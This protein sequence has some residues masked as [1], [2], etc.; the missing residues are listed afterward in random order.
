MLPGPRAMPCFVCWLDR[1][2]GNVLFV[3]QWALTTLC[4]HAAQALAPV[5]KDQPPQPKAS[6]PFLPYPSPPPPPQCADTVVVVSVTCGLLFCSNTPHTPTQA[7]TQTRSLAHST[8]C[9]HTPTLKQ[10]RATH[11][12]W[13]PAQQRARAQL[14]AGLRRAPPVPQRRVEH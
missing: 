11:A 4:V 5:Q 7:H 3:G 9:T 1:A 6:V 2:P 13:Q 12:D 14:S 10:R 8:T